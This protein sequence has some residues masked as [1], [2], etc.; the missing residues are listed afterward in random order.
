MYVYMCIYLKHIY[1]LLKNPIFEL[2]KDS[3][4]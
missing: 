1:I 2:K 3:D 4:Y